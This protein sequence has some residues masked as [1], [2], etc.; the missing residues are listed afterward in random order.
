MQI[1]LDKIKLDIKL[2]E[3]DNYVRGR[4]E[5]EGKYYLPVRLIEEIKQN[6]RRYPKN[7]RMYLGQ[8]LNFINADGKLP[9][10]A[11]KLLEQIYFSDDFVLGMH[12]G[13]QSHEQIIKNDFMFRYKENDVT[14]TIIFNDSLE[15]GMRQFTLADF[16]LACSTKEAISAYKNSCSVIIFAFPKSIFGSEAKP[17][18]A[19]N[20]NDNN[21][22]LLQQF[23]L[24]CF[25]YD[26]DLEKVSFVKN[27]RFNP[28]LEYEAQGLVYDANALLKNKVK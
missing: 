14:S 19:Y 27:P 18:W 8:V 28:S 5:L 1:G 25:Y 16:V 23:V 7:V 10:E 3:L 24:G 6:A 20:E 13:A 12:H 11:G 15:T 9:F 26:Y 21:F 2:K 17:V 22:Y 4:K